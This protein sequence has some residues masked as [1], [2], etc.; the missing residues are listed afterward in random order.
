MI[1]AFLLVFVIGTNEMIISNW[2]F[3]VSFL[4]CRINLKNMVA[5]LKQISIH[6]FRQM[7][8]DENDDAYYELING[9]IMK[10]SAPRPQH[11]RI[12]MRLSIQLGTFIREN[13][14][15]ELFASP[16]DVFLDNLNAVQPDLVFIP[17]ENQAMITDDGIIGIPDLM[18][19]II[20][21]SS[22]LRDRVDKKNLYERLN[23]KE[24]WI[25][26]PQYQ[27]IEVYTVQNGRY[28]LYS[29]VTMFEG[30]LKSAIFE[31]ITIDLAEL[32]V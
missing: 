27:D 18:I 3:G 8:F 31:G 14:L 1:K 30:A 23:V 22:V 11:Q 17:T 29:G 25:I 7:E 13:R 16:I 15:G 20:S 28:E 32:F 26:D 10:K 6:E 19:E 12:S 2:S 4:N 21:P 5:E 24:Y 9:Y